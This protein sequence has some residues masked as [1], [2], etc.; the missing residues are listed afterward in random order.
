MVSCHVML[1]P[2]VWCLVVSSIVSCGVLSSPRSSPVQSS[3]DQSRPVRT[4]S[5]AVYSSNYFFNCRSVCWVLFL[6]TSHQMGWWLGDDQESVFSAVVQTGNQI[7]PFT[8]GYNVPCLPNDWKKTDTQIMKAQLRHPQSR[9]VLMS[10]SQ[11]ST[12]GYDR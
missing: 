3:P 7:L 1:C 4:L 5:L 11:A 10:E 6:K 2:V 9:L 12:G 8:V